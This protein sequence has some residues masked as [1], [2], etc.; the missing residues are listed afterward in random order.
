MATSKPRVS[1]T[2]EDELYAQVTDYQR[3]HGFSSQSKAIRSLLCIALDHSE[4]KPV[5]VK[6]ATPAHEDE[7]DN[8][9]K[10]LIRI[11]REL[12]PSRQE[13]LLRIAAAVAAKDAPRI[14]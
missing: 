13:L 12:D 8:Q 9:E 2:M 3:S 10:E 6:K 4:R 11:A 5:S 7:L 1:V 14:Q